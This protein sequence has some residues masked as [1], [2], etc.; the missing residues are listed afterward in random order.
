VIGACETVAVSNS[1]VLVV[2]V[3]CV[4]GSGFLAGYGLRAVISAN[5]RRHARQ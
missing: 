5:H 1:I 2:F 3:G 4:F